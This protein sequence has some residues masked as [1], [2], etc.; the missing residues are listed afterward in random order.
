MSTMH[1]PADVSTLGDPKL[2]ASD[3]NA[4]HAEQLAEVQGCLSRLPERQ[5]E[6]LR[7][8]LQD[9]LSYKQIAEV[10]G[11]S[12]TNVGYLLHQAVSS[13]RKTLTA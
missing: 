11:L 10:T 8:R 7:L 3:A 4:R 5:Q 13:L 1:S 2:E 6:L 12:Q 9:G